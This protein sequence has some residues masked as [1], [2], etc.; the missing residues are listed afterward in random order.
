MITGLSCLF[1]E[2]LKDALEGLGVDNVLYYPVRLR[3]Q[4]SD[5]TEGGYYLAKI[6]S[7][8]DCIDMEKS[9]TKKWVTGIGFDF[10]SM[11]IDASK[12]NGELIFRLK[13]DPSKII[14]NQTLY[15]HFEETDM[16]VGVDIMKTEDYSDW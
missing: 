8:L 1:H 4:N 6:T 13:D 3:D 15:D 9:K 7:C 14:I 2:D 16:L 11:A 12:T 5:T 10:L